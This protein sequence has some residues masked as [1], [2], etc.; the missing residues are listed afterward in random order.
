MRHLLAPRVAACALVM[1]ASIVAGCGGDPE[2]ES[3]APPK[4]VADAV[5]P[6]ALSDDIQLYE[7]TNEE[8]LEAFAAGGEMSLVA[9]GRLWELRQGARLV[10]ALQVSTTTTRVD[11]ADR[12]QRTSILRQVLPGNLNQLVVDR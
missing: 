10:G 11:L 6:S 4:S 3:V 2:V 9:D 1:A 5:V 12:D 7:N 8:T